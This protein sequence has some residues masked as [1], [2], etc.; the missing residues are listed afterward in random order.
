MLKMRKWKRIKDIEELPSQ[1][2]FNPIYGET[3]WVI[4]WAG[5]CG[6]SILL[7]FDGGSYHHWEL[8]GTEWILE[9]QGG[10]G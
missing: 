6:Y 8:R 10:I 2:S 7:K 9:I 5:K 1:I 4:D 3:D